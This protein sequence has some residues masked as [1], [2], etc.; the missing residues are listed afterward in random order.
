MLVDAPNPP[1][2]RPFTILDWVGMAAAGFSALGLLVFPVAGRSFAAMFQDFGSPEHLPTL[3]KLATSWWFPML[4]G[5]LVAI[6]LVLGTRR[7]SPLGRRRAWIV[8]AFVLG[9]AAFA[10]CLVGA[11]LPIF[12]VAGA[13]KAE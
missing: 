13:M 9:G 5:L 6:G 10:L 7:A 3:T 12:A 2:P 11:Y 4:F 1:E 8:G